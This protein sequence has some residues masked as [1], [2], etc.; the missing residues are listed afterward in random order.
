MTKTITMKIDSPLAQTLRSTLAEEL[1]RLGGS[2]QETT[3]GDPLPM[4]I[5]RY[6]EI[7]AAFLRLHGKPEYAQPVEHHIAINKENQSK[8]E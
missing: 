4:E 1:T 2:I 7:R 3:Y 6:N 8:E 5:E